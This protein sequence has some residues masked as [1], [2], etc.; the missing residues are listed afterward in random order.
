[1]KLYII[2]LALV[3][4][5]STPL[6]AQDQ[7]QYNNYVA[8]QGL[9]NPA[10]NGTRDIIS[11]LLIARSQWIGIDHAPNSQALNVHGPIEDTNLGIGIAISNDMVGFTNNLD[12]LA[13]ASYKVMLDKF[14]FLSFGLQVGVSSNIYDGTKAITDKYNDPV[15]MGKESKIGFNFGFG[16]YLYAEKYFM[17]LSVPKFFTQ[18]FDKK[19]SSFKNT[20]DPKNLYTYLYG[21]YVFD[22]GDVKV[23]PTGL[24]RFVYGAPL[25][26][27]VTANVFLAERF[28]VGL[29]YRST[30]DVVFLADFI[31]NRKL[32][33]RY[34]FDYLIN[35]LNQ[36][37]KYGS[38]EIG[39]QFDF[40]FNKRA[41]MR[42]IRYF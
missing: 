40:S 16:S 25:Q 19:Y 5:C 24:F 15:F 17:G 22:W 2:I 42:S 4:V 13:S 29:G 6:L 41:G 11:G 18:N 9:L 27:D 23:K 32:T 21:G 28:W 26:F 31:I 36:F 20:I 38:H 14:R 7:T 34:S 37:A 30:S 3:G 35:T 33:V 12:V 8:D 10:Y 1:M 39:L